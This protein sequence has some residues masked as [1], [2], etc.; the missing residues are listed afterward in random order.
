MKI[1][2]KTLAR[3]HLERIGYYRLSGYWYCFLH[4][5]SSEEETFKPETSFRSISDLYVF[6][7]RLRLLCLDAIERLKAVVQ[8]TIYTKTG[9]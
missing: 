8:A 7:K 1:S 6:D 4:S 5:P 9:T 3:K 2:D